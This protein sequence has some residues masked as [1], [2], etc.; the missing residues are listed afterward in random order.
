MDDVRTDKLRWAKHKQNR[1][2]CAL[3]DLKYRTDNSKDYWV[4]KELVKIWKELEEEMDEAYMLAIVE[5]VKKEFH[6]ATKKFDKF[7]SEHEGWAVIKEEMDELWEAVRLKQSNPERKDRMKDEAI[8][9][10]AM[11]I[12]FVHDCHK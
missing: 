5:L 7:N 2:Y 12:R 10:A 8:Q 4:S 6:F 9:V 1:A 11:A 3:I